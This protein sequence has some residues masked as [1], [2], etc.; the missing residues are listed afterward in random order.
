MKIY[1]VVVIYNPDNSVLDNIAS[2]VDDVICLFVV[3]NSDEKSQ[4][5]VEKIKGIANCQYI[6]NDGNKGIGQALNMGANLAIQQGADFL[7]TMDQDSRFERGDLKKMIQYAEENDVSNIGI[8]SPM[9]DANDRDNKYKFI[10]DHITMTSG[11]LLNLKIFQEIGVFDEKLF[12]DA[13]DTEYCLRL[14]QFNYRMYRLESVILD[15][16]L[17]EIKKYNFGAKKVTATN[18]NYI[19]RYY[20]MR[21]RLYVWKK[22]FSV[23]PKFVKF[24]VVVTLKELV[25]IV[26]FEENKLLKLKFVVKGFFDFFRNKFGK[27]EL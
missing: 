18:H 4:S 5:I 22:Y 11:N 13:V 24:E 8:I 25:K 21:N 9:H 15:H 19:R 27:I 23:F 1:G 3:D 12:I 26:L 7:L 10:A 20:I 14:Y 16:N 6:D 2:Y 17:G